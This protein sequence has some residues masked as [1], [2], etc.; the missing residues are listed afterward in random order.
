MGAE[1]STPASESALRRPEPNPDNYKTYVEWNNPRFAE[2][3]F[4]NAYMGTWI[5]PREKEGQKCV[6]KERKDTYTWKATD[7][8]VSE[9]IVKKA[10][11][12]AVGFNSFSKTNRPISFTD[13]QVIKVV[14]QRDPNATPK[15]DEH[16]VVENYL[17]GDFKKWCNNYGF[18]SDEAVKTAASLPAF[19][20]W[21]WV[22]TQGQLMIANLQGVRREDRYCLTDPVI[23]SLNKVYGATDMGVEG[24]ALFFLHNKCNDFCKDLRRPQLND[25]LQNPRI[26]KQQIMTCIQVL[27]QVSSATTYTCELQLT[28]EVQIVIIEQFRSYF[29]SILF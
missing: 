20:H 26:P 13:V 29:N 4:R 7:W 24:M 2:G 21:S 23:L 19:M 22:H 14:K 3:R 17:Y 28:E 18:I 9:D 10:K 8:K 15:L 25:F 5:R 27:Q 1:N 16:V 6:V 11:E 12:L